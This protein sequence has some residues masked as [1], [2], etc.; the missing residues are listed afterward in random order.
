MPRGPQAR[1]AHALC[2]GLV[3]RGAARSAAAV[4]A[5]ERRDLALAILDA[6]VRYPLPRAALVP[7]NYCALPALLPQWAKPL[8]ATL[9]R[10]VCAAPL[11]ER[12]AVR[13]RRSAVSDRETYVVKGDSS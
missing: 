12:P 9:L 6:F 11:E 13:T 4:L 1:W 8:A 5:L 3:V 2:L 10:P 7:W